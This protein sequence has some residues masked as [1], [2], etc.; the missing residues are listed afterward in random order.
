MY[1]LGIC[2]MHDPINNLQ[3]QLASSWLT[4]FGPY[5]V[6]QPCTRQVHIL[7]LE[8][9]LVQEEE[10]NHLVEKFNQSLLV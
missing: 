5:Q 10:L 7:V 6:I 3:H 1:A 9:E 4:A 2:Q 8:E